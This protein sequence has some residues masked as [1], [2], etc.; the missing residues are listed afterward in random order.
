MEHCVTPPDHIKFQAQKLFG[1]LEGVLDG[2][3]AYIE[4]GGGGPSTPHT[5]AHNHFFFVVQGQAKVLLDS[6]EI[7]IQQGESYLVQG[8]IPHAVWNDSPGTTVM[9]GISLRGDSQN[10]F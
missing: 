10:V 1:N 8:Q 6:Q 2:S 5:H 4:P 3:I 9:L 7:R